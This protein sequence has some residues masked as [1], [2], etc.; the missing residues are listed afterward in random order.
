MLISTESHLGWY[1]PF[2]FS[3]TLNCHSNS[4]SF[5]GLKRSFL[6]LKPHLIL[7]VTLFLSYVRHDHI[8]LTNHVLCDA[9]SL[10]SKSINP[11]VILHIIV[12][13]LTVSCVLTSFFVTNKKIK[14]CVCR[15]YSN[16]SAL[17]FSNPYLTKN[18]ILNFFENNQG[19]ISPKAYLKG[20]QWPGLQN[21]IYLN[22]KSENFIT[23]FPFLLKM[24][25]FHYNYI[26][27]A[28]PVKFNH[29]GW[30]SVMTLA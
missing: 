8:L 29:T 15:K 4:E 17:F 6:D 18:I 21:K 23:A 30:K 26:F 11:I 7:S 9:Y 2:V 1:W 5:V 24:S 12:I 27:F 20:P 14:L 3:S 16:S 19:I 25:M 10:C 22:Y 28:S 13:P